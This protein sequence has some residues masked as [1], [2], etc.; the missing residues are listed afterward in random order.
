MK[1]SSTEIRLNIVEIFQS[2]Q[3]EG[4]NVG[5]SAIFIRLSGCNKAC[6]YCDTDWSKGDSMS[7]SQILDEVKKYSKSDEYP[8]NLIIWT[9]GEPTLQLTN[10]ILDYF[11]EYYNCIE[12]NGTNPVPS[13]IQYISCSPKVSPEILKVNFERVNE[14]R[15]PISAGDLLPDISELP[16]ADNYFVSPVFLGEEKK[17]FQQVDENVKYAIDFVS[18]NPKWRLS[19]QLH[20]LLNIP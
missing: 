12:T 4:A 15:Y 20:K 10:E 6:W 8:N 1:R 17:R 19:L 2:I 7:V 14:L 18:M 5:R 11:S 13:K 9:G 3:G 16:E